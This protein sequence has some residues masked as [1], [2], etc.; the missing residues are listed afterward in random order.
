MKRDRYFFKEINRYATMY[1]AKDRV[2][3][4]ISFEKEVIVKA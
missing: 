2:R 4:I 3:E 1:P